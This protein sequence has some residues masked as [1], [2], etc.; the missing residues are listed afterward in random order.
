[1]P[2]STTRKLYAFLLTPGITPP[3][4]SPFSH[5]HKLNTKRKTTLI[6]ENVENFIKRCRKKSNIKN[7]KNEFLLQLAPEPV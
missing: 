2:F 6:K 1:M 7:I 5:L 3:F 4:R